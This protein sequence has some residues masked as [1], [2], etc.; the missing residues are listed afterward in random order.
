MKEQAYTRRFPHTTR[1]HQE[2]ETVGFNDTVLN[3]WNSNSGIKRLRKCRKFADRA[4][5]QCAGMRHRSSSSVSET[6]RQ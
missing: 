4:R 5:E 6:V 3:S 2:T 1:R